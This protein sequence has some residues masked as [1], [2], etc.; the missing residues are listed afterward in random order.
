M[1][2][3]SK[4]M[5]TPSPVGKS[6][7]SLTITKDRK[8]R[9]YHSTSECIRNPGNIR[10]TDRYPKT[11]APADSWD[12]LELKSITRK[13]VELGTQG[14][15]LP[16]Q[17]NK[18]SCKTMK[19]TMWEL[20]KLTT[21]REGTKNYLF[22]KDNWGLVTTV[23]C[24]ILNRGL[25]WFCYKGGTQSTVS[26]LTC[27]GAVTEKNRNLLVTSQLPGAAISVGADKPGQKY[28]RKIWITRKPKGTWKRWTYS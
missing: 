28:E 13:L 11:E 16:P 27:N 25:L 24:G 15:H 19:S 6:P 21:G 10:K 26:S 3:K 14:T 1:Q 8:W 12:T 7:W 18:N 17:S 22:K 9:R 20:W 5:V 23:G 2:R 4:C